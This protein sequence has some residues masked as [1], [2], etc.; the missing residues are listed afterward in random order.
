MPNTKKRTEETVE[1][2]RA[3]L[4]ANKP[5]PEN[6][7]TDSLV[8]ENKGTA[9]SVNNLPFSMPSMLTQYF[10][11][12]DNI[13]NDSQNILKDIDSI[14][15]IFEAIAPIFQILIEPIKLRELI[16]TYREGIKESKN[17][18]TSEGIL[19][20]AKKQFL[21]NLKNLSEK[22]NYYLE[23]DPEHL[24]KIRKN[25]YPQSQETLTVNEQI[26]LTDLKDILEGISRIFPDIKLPEI[27]RQKHF[28][29]RGLVNEL[30]YMVGGSA[31]TSGCKALRDPK[32]WSENN[33][34]KAFYQHNKADKSDSYIV[35]YIKDWKNEN[36]IKLMPYSEA[37]QILEKFGVYP[38]LFHLIL[39]VHFYR[40]DD[41]LS[42]NLRLKG[43][44]LIKDLGLDKRTD[45][46]KEEKLNRVLEVITA[47][48][49]LVISAK[50]SSTIKVQK[51]K[52]LID[53]DVFFEVM[54]S[55][56]WNLSPIKITE[57]DLF[58]NEELIDLDIRVKAGAWLGHFFN[59]SGREIGKALYNFATLS[60]KIL[61]LD[62]YHEELALRIALLQ[63]TM[64]YR[65]Y[66][67]VEQWLIEN[68]LGAKDKINKAKTDRNIRRY[69]TNLWDNTLRALERIGFTISYDDKT[70]PENLRPDSPKKPYNYFDPLLMAKVRLTPETLGKPQ[71]VIE[72]KAEQIKPVKQ[73]TEKVYSGADLKLK[74]EALGITQ[75]MIAKYLNKNKMYVSRIE[76]TQVLQCEK[77]NEILDAINY[78]SKY[79]SKFN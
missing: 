31:I 16:E 33:L 72:V 27:F 63:S 55:I 60:Q 62:P 73:I 43:T 67:T 65:Q 44:D 64:D 74:R 29:V 11:D 45:L 34:G 40:Q 42:A 48:R 71:P 25:L 58:G 18:V 35:H 10:K 38:A 75:S 17:T 79:K 24:I 69:L 23:K 26:N 57:K 32:K 53:K 36:E 52:K 66:Y 28:E 7:A 30:N 76:K 77:Y 2:I 51:G 37:E 54:P 6:L 50:W 41:P 9:V 22:L 19:N 56:M 61:D 1:K 20:L 49:S 21:Y 68:L 59:A 12:L 4:R 70:Y 8:N 78:I 5:A 3:K 15:E 39:A 13:P 46:T 14:K 47:V